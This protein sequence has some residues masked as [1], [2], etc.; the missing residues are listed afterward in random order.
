[1]TGFNKGKPLAKRYVSGGTKA[2]VATAKAEAVA[3]RAEAVKAGHVVGKRGPL[4][5]EF[6]ATR[7]G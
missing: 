5:K 4:P 1:V 7:K 6:L 2:K 3:L